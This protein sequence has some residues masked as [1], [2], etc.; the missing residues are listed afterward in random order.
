MIKTIVNL[1]KQGHAQVNLTEYCENQLVIF[2]LRKKQ[3]IASG[4]F[5]FMQGDQ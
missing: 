3:L 5:L 1:K 4:G 2:F